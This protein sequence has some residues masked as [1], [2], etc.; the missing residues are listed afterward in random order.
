MKRLR[1]THK[2]GYLDFDVDAFFPFKKGKAEKVF[3]LI[4]K[5]CSKEVKKE[6][7]SVLENK[8]QLSKAKITL[9]ELKAGI[10]KGKAKYYNAQIKKEQILL[11]RTLRNI[12]LLNID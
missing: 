12:D 4:N 5:Y 6:L 8:A 7:K 1:I 3:E 11:K 10:E 9:Y 2:T